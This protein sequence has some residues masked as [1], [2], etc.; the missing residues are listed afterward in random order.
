MS[1]KLTTIFLTVA[2]MSDARSLF[3]K[4]HKR[5]TR[6]LVVVE[7]FGVEN[8]SQKDE[9]EVNQGRSIDRSIYLK[10]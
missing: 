7:R 2:I 5:K 8:P 3:G 4:L 10:N 9:W 6:N 1:M